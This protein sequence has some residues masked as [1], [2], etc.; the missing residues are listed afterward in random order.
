MFKVKLLIVTP[1]KKTASVKT[2]YVVWDV[3]FRK[4]DCKCSLYRKVII[5]LILEQGNTESTR[6]VRLS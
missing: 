4:T 2:K 5:I 6:Q 1:K 3:I